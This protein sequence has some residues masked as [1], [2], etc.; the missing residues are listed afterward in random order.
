[1]KSWIHVWWLCITWS[2]TIVVE[3]V[4][5]L[6]ARSRAQAVSWVL[7]WALWTV[8]WEPD[9]DWL[10]PILNVISPLID[11]HN[12]EMLVRILAHH[13]PKMRPFWL[14]AT[15]TD[16]SKDISHFLRTLKAPYAC[17]PSV[18]IETF[19]QMIS[20]SRVAWEVS[21]RKNTGKWDTLENL[22]AYHLSSLFC[23]DSQRSATLVCTYRSSPFASSLSVVFR[24]K[25][26]QQLQRIS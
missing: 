7:S 12:Y 23:E 6:V 15:L 20:D 21:K 14:E 9:I 19:E 26:L 16:L 3:L 24:L 4:S 2:L 5:S 1:M 13:R 17:H 11:V 22:E 10:S 8:F 18:K 25:L